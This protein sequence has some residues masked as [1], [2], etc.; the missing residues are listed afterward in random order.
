[1]WDWPGDSLFQYFDPGQAHG[2]DFSVSFVEDLRKAFAYMET[3]ATDPWGNLRA[4]A[5]MT[6]YLTKRL[7]PYQRLRL[8]YCL[9]QAHY[10][11]ND[12]SLALEHLEAAAE[13]ADQLDDHNASAAL[14]YKAALIY[15]YMSEFGTARSLCIDVLEVLHTAESATDPEFAAK[16]A[17]LLMRVATL[18]SELADFG[19]AQDTT[20]EAR[21]LLL[22]SKTS[23]NEEVNYARLDWIDAV[24]ANWTG[25]PDQALK[26]AQASADSY[27]RLGMRHL[28]GR[29][30]AMTVEIALDF[31]RDFTLDGNPY[32]RAA[33]ARQARPHALAAIADARASE[34]IVGLQLGHLVLQGCRRLR[35]PTQDGVAIVERVIRQA[36]RIGDPALLGR[37]YMSLGDE[38]A[39]QNQRDAARSQYGKAQHIFEEFELKMLGSWPSRYLLRSDEF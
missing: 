22:T 21:N 18:D 15:Q 28:A 34:D 27:T 30:H 33:F 31:A 12:F 36:K 6:P 16:K 2:A 32:L 4:A 11:E 17:V 38:L 9:A 3:G 39:A 13:I 20:R 1:M 29:A 25:R 26:L 19:H 10:K 35:G 14:G 37:A 24:V 7:P 23:N 5:L 8:E